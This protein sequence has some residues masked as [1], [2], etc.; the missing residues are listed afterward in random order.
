M[1]S[2][3]QKVDVKLNQVVHA[4]RTGQNFA[5][6]TDAL[7]VSGQQEADVIHDRECQERLRRVGRAIFTGRIIS[8]VII[9]ICLQLNVWVD[10]D[11]NKEWIPDLATTS[12]ACT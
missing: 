4:T 5:R 3:S 9:N 2:Q 10:A 7:E 11:R 8:E 6:R 12:S 1:P